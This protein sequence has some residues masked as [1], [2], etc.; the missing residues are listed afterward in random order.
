MA[1]PEKRQVKPASTREIM[2]AAAV[3]LSYVILGFW[4]G[5]MRLFFFTFIIAVVA[6]LCAI[7]A[8]FVKKIETA[9][10]EVELTKKDELKLKRLEARLTAHAAAASIKQELEVLQENPRPGGKPSY[11]KGG[12]TLPGA[13]GEDW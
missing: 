10:D 2:L 12:G 6:W 5:W 1:V 4:L 11:D 3:L 8:R 9:D 7:L 13:G